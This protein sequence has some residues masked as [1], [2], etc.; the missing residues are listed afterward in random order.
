M[1]FELI[2]SDNTQGELLLLN[3]HLQDPRVRQI[4]QSER[5]SMGDHWRELLKI[6]NGEWICFMGGDDGLVSKN[7]PKLLSLLRLTDSKVVTTHRIEI[8]WNQSFS[9][10]AWTF[11]ISNCAETVTKVVWPTWLSSLFPQF[12]FDLPM[13][14][15]RAVFRGE[16]LKSFLEKKFKLYDLTPDYFLAFL[17]GNLTKKGVFFDLPVFVHGGSEHSNGYQSTSG[18]KT[19]YSEDF[20]SRIESNLQVA[21]DLPTNCQSSWLAN[22]YLLCRFPEKSE[23]SN[24]SNCSF[25]RMTLSKFYKIWIYLTCTSCDVHRRGNSNLMIKTKIVFLNKAASG[26]RNYLLPIR[27]NGQIP[28]HAGIRRTGKSEIR[29]DNLE[30]YL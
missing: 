16:V 20:L 29:L 12:F 13:P 5:L 2:I 17:L 24:R 14:Y 28:F 25:K 6:A 26:I 9:A 27:Q 10:S 4:V 19:V 23:Y 1:D 18:N 8:D 7:L 21:K 3:A 30:N 15:N 22:S 11:P